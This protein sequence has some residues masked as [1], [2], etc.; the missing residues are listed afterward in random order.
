MAPRRT[1]QP[2]ADFEST[3]NRARQAAAG[4]PG[5]TS[6]NDRSTADF[7]A[8]IGMLGEMVQRIQLQRDSVKAVGLETE[9][10]VQAQKDTAA[11]N[12]L[13][14]DY[15][16]QVKAIWDAAKKRVMDGG[17][18]SGPV[19]DDLSK[20]MDRHSA[21]MQTSAIGETKRAV[22]KQAILG[23]TDAK[24]AINAKIRNDPANANLYMGEFQADVERLKVGMDPVDFE[25]V[26]RGAADDFA[27]NQV[28]G[29]AEKGN[30]AAAKGALKAQAPRLKTEVVT[31]LSSY[32][33]GKESKARA[34]GDRA[35]TANAST[36]LL[37]IEDQFNGRKPIDPNTR[38]RL[39]DMK[40]KGMISPEHHLVAVKTWNREN[41][42]YQV[43]AQ[44]NAKAAEE[45]TTSTLSSQEN[46]DRAFAG[47][48]GNIPFG[49]IAMEGTPEQKAAGILLATTMASGSG[50]LPSQMK[51]LI[52]NAD[53][54]TNPKQAAAVSYAAEAMDEIEAKAP[55][56][57]AG[58]TLSDT[59]VVNRTRAEAKR[60][61]QDG[62]PRAE[63]YAQAAQTQMPKDKMT[64][65]VETDLT[66][67]AT[68]KLKKMNP[69][70]EALA[71]VT[72]WGERNIP[73]VATPEIGAQMG[74]VY[75]RTFKEA[76]VATGGDEVRAKALANKKI[77][78]TYG[79]TKVGVIDAR[80][81]EQGPGFEEFGIAPGTTGMQGQGKVT[82]QAYPP[83]KYL[84]QSFPQMSDDQL[85]K[86]IMAD[87][88]RVNT[89]LGIAPNPSKDAG[90]APIVQFVPDAQ[91]ADDIRKGR[92]DV[93]YQY[94]VLRGDIYEPIPTNNGPL[95]Y[96]LPTS[97]DQVKDNP[98]YLEAERN[99]LAKDE[100][101]RA[102][103][104]EV[105]KPVPDEAADERLRRM[106]EEGR[107]LKG[108]R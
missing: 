39:D 40:A 61:M 14:K 8:G 27:K 10:T 26:S 31:G 76:M 42:K 44:K 57:I 73:F 30:F 47:Q 86:M 24:E 53:N 25:V 81:Q 32:I 34:D 62:V 96:R 7:A 75:E 84:K 48:Y 74:Q 46:A 15:Q 101:A 70:Q 22:N 56:K 67:V 99:R 68:D 2:E 93:S 72:S 63:A 50:Y 66:A 83:E 80:Q 82:I 64:L 90:G 21:A 105:K 79:P 20:R 6:F 28:I 89:K 1:A 98:A 71:A 35:R 54:I 87:L 97:V 11:L 55:G 9:A 12:P 4:N 69:S 95:R 77:T 29:Y 104:I 106:R 100:K 36:I 103:D 43:E 17:L 19:L 102:L 5:T 3:G 108:N 60:L 37:D 107:K 13:D 38:E 85:A 18:T 59:G 33:D 23:Y 41:E 78:D 94:R 49:R 91:T 16:T 52:S 58:V 51:N 45:L 65:Q 88:D 92:R